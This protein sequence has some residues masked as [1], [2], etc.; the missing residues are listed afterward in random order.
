M[1]ISPKTMQAAILTELKQPLVLDEV[2]IPS[3]LA[4]GQVLVKLLTTSICGAQLGE[5]EGAKGADPYLPHLLGHEGVGDVIA[6]GPGVTVVKASERVVLHWRKGLG[7]DAKPALYRWNDKPLNAGWVTTF[8]QYAI[9]SENRVTPVSSTLDPEIGALFGCAVT[10]ALGVLMNNA[11]L[12][13]GESVVVFGVGGVGLNV[14]QGAALTT[15]HPIIAVD[16]VDEKLEL[17]KKLGATHTIN[18][19]KV[20]ART[21]IAKILGKPGADVIVECTGLVD[22]IQTA[23]DLAGPEGRII[24]VGV[25]KKGNNISIYSLPLHFGKLLTGSHGGDTNPTTD[26]PRYLKLVEAGKLDLSQI[27]THRFPFAQINLAI[28]MMRRGEIAGRCVL[29]F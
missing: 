25:P 8:N 4:P 7:I 15:A 28:D 22:V 14:V 24:L 6:I 1:S 11:K 2:E 12:K 26:I 3:E 13:L 21:E 17:A 29:S 27:I 9:V 23:Y 5:I 18:S 19:K 16:L 20:D 10:S